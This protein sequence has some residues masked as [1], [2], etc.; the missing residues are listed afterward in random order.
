MTEQMLIKTYLENVEQI[1]LRSPVYWLPIKRQL[2]KKKFPM[3]RMSCSISV[4]ILAYVTA[5]YCRNQ[6]NISSKNFFD[7]NT[8]VH[9]SRKYSFFFTRFLT[10]VSYNSFIYLFWTPNLSRIYFYWLYHH[11]HNTQNI[12]LQLNVLAVAVAPGDC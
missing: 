9:F 11:K 1:S 7:M 5:L 3:K 4:H 2:L 12:R 6:S 8:F 10:V